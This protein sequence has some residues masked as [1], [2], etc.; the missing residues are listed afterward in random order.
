MS[1]KLPFTDH[2]GAIFF[3]PAKDFPWWCGRGYPDVRKLE[4]AFTFGILQMLVLRRPEPV[5]GPNEPGKKCRRRPNT[6]R[7]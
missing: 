3:I 6:V 2:P 4:R 1:G 5:R 7:V